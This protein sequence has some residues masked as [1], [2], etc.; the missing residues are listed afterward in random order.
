MEGKDDRQ[1]NQVLAN[2]PENLYDMIYSVFSRI[3]QDDEVDKPTV[4]RLL[5]WVAF[6]KR[7]LSF[8]ELDV[9]LR[10]DFDATNWFLWDHLRGKF[11][12][13][14]RLRYPRGFD[15]DAK[16]EDNVDEKGTE[17]GG[18]RDEPDSEVLPDDDDDNGSFNLDDSSDDE[19][20]EEAVDAE[21][22][23]KSD[24]AQQEQQCQEPKESEA[25]Q[26]YSWAQ[27]HTVVDFSHQRFRDFLVIE[28]DPHTRQKPSLPV[29]I[30]IHHVEVDIVFD[31]FRCLRAGLDS[32]KCH[33]TPKATEQAFTDQLFCIGAH[34]Q[35]Y[36]AYP[37]FQLFDHLASLKR[38]RLDEKT[39]VHILRELYWL[40]RKTPL[41]FMRNSFF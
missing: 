41:K 33:Q 27:K 3:S 11:A 21:E 36:I 10:S 38:D 19:A 37:A 34:V 29:G 30:D 39:Q 17:G 14:F 28:G 7:P 6:A 35:Y 12:S 1:I 4:N 13:T 25:D 18:Q 9:I 5:A 23:E 40:M 26:H 22:E 31:C 24:E 20:E 32:G 8:G 2:P 15:P 16:N